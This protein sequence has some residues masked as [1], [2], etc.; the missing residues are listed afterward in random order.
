MLVHVT[1]PSPPQHQAGEW[2]QQSS[3]KTRLSLGSV[4]LGFCGS[5]SAPTRN[6]SSLGTLLLHNTFPGSTI[7]TH[8]IIDIWGISQLMRCAV[9][10]KWY[11][12]PDMVYH[13]VCFINPAHQC[14]VA[15][16]W[17]PT[18]LHNTNG[19]RTQ[20]SLTGGVE[21]ALGTVYL[22]EFELCAL[23]GA[24]RATEGAVFHIGRSPPRGASSHLPATSS[25][26]MGR[27]GS[28]AGHTA[29]TSTAGVRRAHGNGKRCNWD[30][31]AAGKGLL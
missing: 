29:H 8:S 28:V 1:S 20:T 17:F 14:H 27:W 12:S 10:C 13:S 31:N 30:P 7:P 26:G 9:K 16:C 24:P 18:T 19:W 3:K 21:R 15:W 22:E 6:G 2:E 25:W 5:S 11:A 4:C 23:H